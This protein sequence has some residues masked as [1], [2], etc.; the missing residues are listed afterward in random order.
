MN[1]RQNTKMKKLIL[2]IGIIFSGILMQAQ[3]LK[4]DEVDEFTGER[5][6]ITTRERIAKIGSYRVY[7]QV[8]KNG[9]VIILRIT[10]TA[11][12]GCGGANDNYVVLK[13]VDGSI[14]KLT[15]DKLDVNCDHP[16]SQSAYLL[17]NDHINKIKS[18]ELLDIRIKMS[19]HSYDFHV[20]KKDAIE[21]M[22]N[23]IQ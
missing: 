9:T 18:V 10:T 14:I 12:L 21:N 4:T 3:E 20:K 19:S 17:N 23:L 16:V 11:G 1:I 6:K 13:F 8:E 5:I 7:A 22:I 15:D 2:I